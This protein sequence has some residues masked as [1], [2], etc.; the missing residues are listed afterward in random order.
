MQ[1]IIHTIA[2]FDATVGTTIKFSWSGN[3]A[4]KNRCIIRNNDTQEVVYDKTENS[5]KLE[6]TIDLSSATLQNGI[7]Y[8]AYITVF[9]NEDIESDIQSIGTPFLCL[10]TPTFCFSNVTEG[11]NIGASTYKFQLTYEQSNG[12]L[13]NSWAVSV[14]STSKVELATSGIQYNTDELTYDCTGF[15]DKNEYFV[16]AIGSTINGYTLDTG[17]INI[18]VAYTTASV[19]SVLDLTNLY[20]TGS[21]H[22]R[23]NI[24]SAEGKTEKEPTYLDNEA[25]DLRNNTLIYDEGFLFDGDFSL[26]QYFY[27]MLANQSVIKFY[28]ENQN[29]LFGNV[30]YRVVKK[31]GKFKSCFELR[32]RTGSLDYVLYS[33]QIDIVTATDKVG[34]CIVRKDNLYVIQCA[35]LSD[36]QTNTYGDVSGLTWQEANKY[37]WLELQSL[38]V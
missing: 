25:I 2:P 8:I 17:Y 7:K 12:E 37:T 38:K 22:I 15:S 1:A 3:Q 11:Q 18:S 9:D 33:N 27:G 29:N 35:K 4:F 5:F 20:E 21:I 34:I 28:G 26:I 23:S 24:V 16:R 19:F 32:I 13:L 14:Y 30:I 36:G 31:D 10:E 6:H